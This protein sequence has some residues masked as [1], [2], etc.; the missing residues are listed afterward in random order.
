MDFQ[1][2][3]AIFKIFGEPLGASA[4]AEQQQANLRK[5]D[6]VHADFF[7][8]SEI[9][10]LTGRKAQRAKELPT[11]PE[12]Q[13]AIGIEPEN[14]PGSFTK[15]LERPLLVN[16]KF[17]RAA[18]RLISKAGLRSAW[19]A[20]AEYA[21]DWQKSSAETAIKQCDGAVVQAL[22]REAMHASEATL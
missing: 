2:E 11:V 13:R 22:L 4:A 12:L 1:T 10:F 3:S 14:Q 5:A 8:K 16:D 17:G 20:F 15:S 9:D 7:Q 19:N 21:T 18:R 6:R